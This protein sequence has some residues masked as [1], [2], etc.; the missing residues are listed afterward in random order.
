M[1][2]DIVFVLH[3]MGKYDKDWLSEET[4]AVS[5]ARQGRLIRGVKRERL[6]RHLTNYMVKRRAGKGGLRAGIAK[7]Q[8]DVAAQE[9]LSEEPVSS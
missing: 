5:L 2:K 9:D 1:T 4:G 8:K 7:L 6:E 3:G